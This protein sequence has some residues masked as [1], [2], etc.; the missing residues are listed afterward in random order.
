MKLRINYKTGKTEILEV[1]SYDFVQRSDGTLKFSYDR[2][3]Y[4]NDDA[5][6]PVF[7]N[8]EAVESIW[9]MGKSK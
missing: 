8:I 4:A 9:R 3:K 2:G 6:Y 7:F 1:E 5:S